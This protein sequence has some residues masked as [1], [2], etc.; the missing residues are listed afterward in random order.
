MLYYGVIHM[1]STAI[2]APQFYRYRPEEHRPETHQE[3]AVL[4][5]HLTRIWG[6]HPR[7]IRIPNDTL[8]WPTKSQKAMRSLKELAELALM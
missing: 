6:K 4:D 7:Y 3:A 1:V 8:D 5:E 2:G